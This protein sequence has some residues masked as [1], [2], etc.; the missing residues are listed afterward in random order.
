M[1]RI[2]KLCAQGSSRTIR[3]PPRSR[4]NENV[5]PGLRI[6]QCRMDGEI[7]TSSESYPSENASFEIVSDLGDQW[8]QPA[9]RSAVGEAPLR[10]ARARRPRRRRRRLYRP[11]SRLGAKS[12]L[13]L[14]I[15]DG[16]PP[17]K[18]PKVATLCHR[19]SDP[20][21]MVFRPVSDLSP[22]SFLAWE[23]GDEEPL[24]M[25]HG[26]NGRHPRE[27]SRQ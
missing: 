10:E 11:A 27:H 18:L 1:G 15:G 14:E 5:A 22:K 8:C 13:D 20:R 19:R 23:I 9:Q 2:G 6:R 12:F 4:K 26:S 3:S 7:R 24:E 21:W 16:D 25:W 17:Q